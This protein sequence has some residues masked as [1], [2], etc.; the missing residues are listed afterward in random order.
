V[1]TEG[2]FIPRDREL[3][4]TSMLARIRAAEERHHGG[5]AL[6]RAMLSL[7]QGKVLDHALQFYAFL[8]HHEAADKFDK[9]AAVG[10]EKD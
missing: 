10:E 2:K 6:W 3:V 1:T 8:K 7:A 5:R 9:C 4:V